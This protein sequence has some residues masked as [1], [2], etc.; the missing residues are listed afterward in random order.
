M[1]I[2]SVISV[3]GDVNNDGYDDVIVGARGADKAYIFFGGSSMDSTADVTMS[4]ESSYDFFGYGTGT[5]GDVNKDGYSDVIIGAPY[6]AGSGKAYIYFGGSSMDNVPD[7]TIAGGTNDGFGMHVGF[8]GD[9]DGDGDN[10]FVVAAPQNNINGN[11]RTYLYTVIAESADPVHNV[12]T[13]EDFSTIQAAIDDPDTLDGHTITVDAGTYVENVNVNKRLTLVGEG[14]DAVTVTAAS[15]EDHVFEVTADYVD[16][17]GFTVTGATDSWKAGIYLGFYV[18]HCNISD[19][20]AS[21]NDL[22]IWLQRSSDNTLTGN[23]ANSNNDSGFCLYSSNDNTLTGNTAVNNNG[24]GSIAIIFSSSN[25][26]ANNIVNSNNHTGILLH[27]SS[28]NTLANNI[29]NSNT[30]DGIYLE[31]C[32]SKNTLTNNTASLNGCRGIYLYASSSNMLANNTASLNGNSGIYLFSSS[33]NNMLAGN[34]ANSN[35]CY[36]VC[37]YYSSNNT[38]YNNCFNNTNNAYDDGNNTWNI[39]PTAG[40]NIIGGSLLGGNYWCDYDGADS[41]GDGLGDSEYPIAG[42]GNFD[43]HPLCQTE[44]S[45]KGDLNSDDQITPADA[46]IALAIAATGAHDDAADVSGD[47]QVTSLDA[48]MI[49]QAAADRIEL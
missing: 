26:L 18:D 23:T 27:S 46:A 10:D 38:I 44:A 1:G 7:I 20:N 43:Y 47:G 34:T 9:V 13:G 33:N 5:V 40:K 15:V 28:Y 11:G 29:V 48:L 6:C 12:D 49:L 36:G 22:G 4:G 24:S 17:S 19:N 21:N 2:D 25:T 41:D 8:A 30:G 35:N 45:V 42:G 31:R 37:L 32:P 3:F 14:A 16:I 39:T